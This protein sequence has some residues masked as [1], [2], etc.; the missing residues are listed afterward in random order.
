MV[1]L[2]YPSVDLFDLAIPLEVFHFA[3]QT[4]K[5]MFKNHRKAYKVKLISNVPSVSVKTGSGP[6]V[7]VEKDVACFRGKVDTL[8]VPGGESP[9]ICRDK[10]FL[11]HFK[12]IA[13]KSSRIA[14]VCTGAFVLADAGLL[15]GKSCTTHW[16]ACE[17]LQ[18]LHPRVSVKEDSIFV[19]D[20]NIFTSA[21]SSAG[22]DLLLHLVEKDHGRDVSMSIAR[23]LVVFLRRPGGQSQFSETLQNQAADSHVMSDLIPWM[24]NNLQGD[25]RVEQLAEKCQ[26][27]VRNFVRQFPKTLGKTPARYVESLR[28]EAAKRKLEQ[29]TDRSYHEIAMAVGF[30]SVDSMRRSFLRVVGVTPSDYRRSF[31]VAD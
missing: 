3:N 30:G 13:D 19:E 26:M 25:L 31:G 18:K 4:I 20:K 1:V 29:S 10:E 7:C 22:I 9:G 15:D 11:K 28:I 8:V 17:N 14:S 21:G 12:R 27:S 5:R 16:R 2:V 23:D 24:M 6:E